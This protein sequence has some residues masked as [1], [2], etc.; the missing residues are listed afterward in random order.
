VALDRGFLDGDLLWW[1]KEQ[2][3]IDWYCPAKEGMLVTDEARQRVAAVLSGQRQGDEGPLDTARRLSRQGQ[4]AYEGVV[5]FERGKGPGRDRLVVAQV[6]DLMCTEFYGPGG[7]SSSRVH[8]KEFRCTPL[9]ATVV[10]N[11]PDRRAADRQDADDND[12]FA[13][14]ELVLLSPDKEP[15]LLRFDRYDARSL[16][17]NRLNREGKQHFGLSMSLAR[18]AAAM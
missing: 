9:H 14:R 12:E 11:W 5:F 2:Q 18:N 1:L 4:Q 3:G 8:S 16:I 17:E 6:D 10:L 13:E 15:G 7:R